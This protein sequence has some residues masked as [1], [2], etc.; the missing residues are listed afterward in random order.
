MNK[1]VF[2]A[3]LPRAGSTLLGT[4]LKQNPRFQ[5]SIS[6]PLARYT[7]AII[8][9]SSAQGGYRTECPPEKRK[10][11]IKGLF[12]SYYDD[13]SKEVCV[14]HNRGWPLLLPT[15]KDLYP[16]SKLIL[17]VRDIDQI[18]NSFEWLVRKQPYEFTSMFSPDESISVYSRCE[19]LLS[20]GRTLDFAYTAV[21]E[22][23]TGEYKS[24]IMIMEYNN[25]AKNPEV[26]MKAFYSFIVEPYYPHDFSDVEA[27]YDEF[28][29]DVRLKGLHTTRKVVSFQ[30]KEMIIPPDIRERVKGM[31]VWR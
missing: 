15:I 4:I 17:C 29:E 8:H 2:T 23:I 18:L 22:A 28:D 25:L 31:E 5:A 12:N 26:M 19:S 30:E 16:D 11:L 14:N 20:R 10:Q 21:K 6:G 27:S 1:I 13:P 3:G 24:S 9:E 7:R